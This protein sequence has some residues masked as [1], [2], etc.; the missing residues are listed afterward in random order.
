LIRLLIWH[1]IDG[2][3]KIRKTPLGEENVKFVNVAVDLQ[4][5]VIIGRILLLIEMELEKTSIVV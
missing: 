1:L 3:I 2:R 5:T 4:L